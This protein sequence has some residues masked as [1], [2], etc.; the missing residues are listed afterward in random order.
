MTEIDAV[1]LNF[2]PG[3]LIGLNL[4][5]A[6][7][8]FGVALDMKPSDFKGIVNAP[9]A[10]LMGLLGQFLLLPAIAWALG[11]ILKPAPSIA[12][13]MILVSACPGGNISNF[14]THFARGNTALSITISAFSTIGSLFFTPFNLSFW[15]SMNPETRAILHAVQ[16]SP[17][18]VLM[19]IVFLLGVPAAL[20][21][22]VA[23]RWPRFAERLHKPFKRL[24][25]VVFGLF[26]VGALAANWGYFIQHVGRV[27]AVVFVM[28]ALGLLVGYWSARL[29]GLPE[30]DRRAVS[31]EV[32]IQNSGFGLVL[33]FNFFD[34]L[35]GMAIVAAWWGIWHIL[36]GT[37]LATIWRRY[38]PRQAVPAEVPA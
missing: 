34:G 18:E 6:L 4:I 30:A 23:Y 7:V 16:L 12:L 5:L 11:M 28:N 29:V 22:A 21:M 25:L 33:V 38:P 1:R 13:G 20:G 35:G 8:L 14:L 32:G 19:A 15:G 26:I 24:S 2:N 31:M 36:V 10:T 27:V 17:W 37:T 3:S 9:R